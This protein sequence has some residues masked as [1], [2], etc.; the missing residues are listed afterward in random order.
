LNETDEKTAEEADLLMAQEKEEEDQETGPLNKN[1]L[2]IAR[3]EV[4]KQDFA[5]S[6]KQK[7]YA[8]V[9]LLIILLCNI[10]N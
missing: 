3:V 2:E 6:R 4:A 5:M 1:D 10:S 9:V 8:W 7:C